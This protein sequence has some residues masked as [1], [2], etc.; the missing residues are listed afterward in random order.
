MFA[1]GGKDPTIHLWQ[2]SPCKELLTIRLSPGPPHGGEVAWD[3][4]FSPD[5]KTLAAGCIDG[6]ARLLDIATG[7]ELFKVSELNSTVCSVAFSP[8]G[9]LLAGGTHRRDI[10][11]WQV[12]TGKLE[13][14]IDVT[15]AIFSV[16]FSPRGD[17]LAS[18]CYDGTVRL[19]HMPSGRPGAVFVSGPPPITISG[20]TGSSQAGVTSVA[21]S[22]DGKTLASGAQERPVRLWE[23]ATGKERRRFEGHRDQ[24]WSLAFSPDGKTL[25]SGSRDNSI[26]L[27]DLTAAPR[28]LALSTRELEDSWTALRSPDATRAYQAISALEAS[29]KQAVSFLLG[30]LHLATAVDQRRTNKLI[31]DLDSERFSVREQAASELEGMGVLAGKALRQTRASHQSAEVRSR[32][33]RLLAKL[34]G[35][36]ASSSALCVLRA[37][38][39]LE[40][41]GTAEAREGLERLGELVTENRMRDEI[42]ASLN[43][44]KKRSKA[45]EIKGK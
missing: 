22:P 25:A 26:L 13:R 29:P 38:E 36:L 11:V 34:D 4:A 44:M 42:E 16:A 20:W 45:V 23:V 40:Y 33:E 17:I 27:W 28:T 10:F 18:G 5:G 35:P 43:R 3:L 1:A 6:T 21:F 19:W 12:A 31:A 2:V 8:D 24:V 37:T 41:I 30:R 15:P 39:I 7:K 14:R 9:R 32:V